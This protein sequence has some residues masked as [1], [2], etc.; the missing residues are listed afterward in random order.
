M[1]SYLKAINASPLSPPTILTP[2]SGIDKLRKNWR[3]SDE[4]ADHDKF[5][6][7]IITLIVPDSDAYYKIGTNFFLGKI[8]FFI[9][10]QD[11]CVLII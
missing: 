5:C 9:Y 8:I 6:R 7:R 11:F 3:M 1:L 2:P 10:L 4:F